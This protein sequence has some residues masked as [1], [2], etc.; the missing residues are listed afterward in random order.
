MVQAWR[1]YDP[2]TMR[3]GSGPAGAR[4][5]RPEVPSWTR[6]ADWAL[7]GYFAAQAIVGVTLWIAA[8]ASPQV[9]SWFDIAPERKAVVDAFLYPD[10]AVIVSSSAS[11]A[12]ALARNAGW[13]AV[14]AAF[15]AGGVMY[16]TVY[17]LGWVGLGAGAG[18]AALAIMIPPALLTSWT[19]I[20][21]YRRWSW[22]AN[23][24]P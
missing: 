7:A 6:A 4:K 3:R 17:L 2:G 16:P 8:S 5:G 9:R 14:S 13:A 24:E 10:I 18:A 23:R 22:P 12:Y 15:C 11:T 19:A 20:V 1:R 21:I